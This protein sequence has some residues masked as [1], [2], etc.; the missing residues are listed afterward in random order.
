MKRQPT[1][2]TET[3]LILCQLGKKKINYGTNPL[4]MQQIW[5]YDIAGGAR[6]VHAN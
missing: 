2:T 4:Y 1:M 5:K 6:F 3:E